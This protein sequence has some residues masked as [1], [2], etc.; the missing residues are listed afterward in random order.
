M[1]FLLCE[2][3]AQ[4]HESIEELAF[5][6]PLNEDLDKNIAQEL[7]TKGNQY[8]NNLFEK[9]IPPFYDIPDGTDEQYYLYIPEFLDMFS[10]ILSSASIFIDGL[11]EFLLKWKRKSPTAIK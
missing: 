11:P 7:S 2:N 6:R 10:P 1:G 4:I 5:V 8:M 9:E 3:C